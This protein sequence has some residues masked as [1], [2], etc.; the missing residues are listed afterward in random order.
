MVDKKQSS[1]R[2]IFKATSLFGGVQVYQILIQ[3]IKS[4]FIAVLLG[5]AGVGIMGLYQSGLQLIQSI[6][7]MGLS[8]SAVR[9]VSEANGSTNIHKIAKT[10]TVVRRLVWITGLLGL[11]LTVCLSPLLSKASFG[12]YDYTIPFIILSVTLL[13]DQLSAGQKVVLQGMRRLKDLAKCSAYGVTFGLITSVPL[14]YWLGID[15]I[16]P[17]LILNSVCSLILSWLYSKKIKIE[18]VQVTTRQTFEQ[19]KLML[20]MGISISLSGIFA[21]I[22]SY[23][24]RGF[25]QGSGGVEQVGLYQAGFVIMT[26]YVGMVMNA[27]ATDYY[28]RLAAINK[29]NV[30]CA[31]AVSQQGEIGT[32]ILAPMLTIC[33]VFMPFMLRILYSDQFL[34]ANEYIS[35]A[36]LGM[37]LR[38]GAW[39]ISFLFVAKAESKM[40]IINE[41]ASNTYYLVLSLVGY[42]LFGL[43]G[44]GIAFAIEYVLY[45]I[46][47]YVI[48]RIRYGFRFSNGFIKCYGIQLLLIVAC[49]VVVLNFDGWQKYTIGCLII[50]ISCYL[51]LKGLNQRMGIFSY[52]KQKRNRY[53]DQ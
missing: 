27:I 40:F 29:D 30:K 35:W 44:L 1:Y 23:A 41:L 33:L 38:L 7:S 10:V 34:A 2:S 12:N 37:M 43:T 5:P 15:G 9:D 16:I 45:F 32:M 11:V 19:G 39:V 8:S 51:G 53:D 52:V 26:T 4:K 31:E 46:Q 42:H 25:I 24:I 14:Y 36:C 47:C 21:T 3:I 6:S 13:I 50:A 20:V 18:K 48:A 49:L 17:T 22:V 28:P